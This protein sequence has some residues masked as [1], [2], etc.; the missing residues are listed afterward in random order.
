MSTNQLDAIRRVRLEDI[1]VIARHYFGRDLP[2]DDAG[3]ET[4]ELMLRCAP[5]EHCMNII[6]ISAPWMPADEAV[7]MVSRV[8]GMVMPT[9]TEIGKEMRVTL[10]AKEGLA[11]AQVVPH[12]M[13]RADMKERR[14]ERKRLKMR[15]TRRAK[16][17]RSREEYEGRSLSKTK[18]WVAAGMSSSQ[19]VPP[20]A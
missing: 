18:P 16:G 1:R 10:E 7:V 8:R 15:E 19:V 9:P 14:K 2:D 13:S 17:V 20:A 3:R 12:D 4:L 5:P 11:L 6:E